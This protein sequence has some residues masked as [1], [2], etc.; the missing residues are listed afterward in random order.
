MNSKILLL[1]V[2]VFS[3]RVYSAFDYISISARN[4]ALAS[5]YLASTKI[6]DAFLLNPALSVNNKNI[7]AGLNYS[8]LFNLED[9]T[10]SMGVFSFSVKQNCIGLAIQNFG[11]DIYRENKITLNYAR[12]LIDDKLA[13]GISGILYFIS[14]ANYNN[15]NTFG[16]SFGFRY[17]T[18]PSLWIAGAIEN[19]NRPKLN[20]Y[21]EEV[22]QLIHFG[23]Q[24]KVLDELY[25]H[26]S[27]QKDAWFAPI[28]SFGIEYEIIKNLILSSGFTSAASLPSLGILLNIS[29]IEIDYSIQHHFDLGPT[30]FVGIAYSAG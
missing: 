25:S 15:L 27:V 9:L 20:G 8:R 4:A 19:I 28:V 17:K 23:L 24:Y 13:I 22:P 10:Y 30:H 14:V 16:F 5:S 21:S 12:N 26:I 29:G 11:E 18:S 3:G 1:T 7:Y 6:S 2:L